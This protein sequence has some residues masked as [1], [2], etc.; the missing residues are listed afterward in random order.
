M[1]E[2]RILKNKVTPEHYNFS[3]KN[4]NPLLIKKGKCSETFII[5]VEENKYVCKKYNETHYKE[6]FNEIHVLKNIDNTCYF[7]NFFK[8]LEDINSRYILYPFLDGILLSKFNE[9]DYFKINDDNSIKHILE[10]II[11]ALSYLLKLNLAY[12]N[13]TPDNILISNYKPLSIKLIDLKYC[14]NITDKKMKPFRHY[15]YCS[16]ELVFQKKYY[17]NSDVWS[18]GCILYYIITN[19]HLFFQTSDLYFD[20]LINFTNFNNYNKCHHIPFFCFDIINKCLTSIHFLRPSLNNVK[21]FLNKNTNKI[22]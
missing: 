14:R 3:I 22:T 12:L 4:Y 10:Q 5:Y 8:N 19:K 6:Y 15:G 11:D 20:Q 2:N 13:L 7:P 16:P 21:D 1:R 9:K 17:H 18:V